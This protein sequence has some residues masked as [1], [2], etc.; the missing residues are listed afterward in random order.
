[1]PRTSPDKDRKRTPFEH[2]L[3]ARNHQINGFLKDKGLGSLDWMNLLRGRVGSFSRK[4]D[5]KQEEFHQKE[6]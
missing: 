3:H 2:Y 6:F 4:T 5:Q 1:M